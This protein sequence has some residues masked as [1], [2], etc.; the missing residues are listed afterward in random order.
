MVYWET[1]YGFGVASGI[2]SWRSGRSPARGIEMLGTVF[3]GVRVCVC[4]CVR[5]AGACCMVCKFRL[6]VVVVV[7]SGHES[8]VGLISSSGPL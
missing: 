4:A 6:V 7:V 3:G 2:N 8:A 1:L 5:A